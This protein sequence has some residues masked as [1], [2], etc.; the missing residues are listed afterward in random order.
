VA[1]LSLGKIRRIQ[2]LADDRGIFSICAMDHRGSLQR[3]LNPEHPDRVTYREMVDFK[4]DLCRA[5]APH[6]S[7]VLLDPPYGAGQAIVEGA[8][9]GGTALLVSIEATGYAG[10]GEARATELLPN[11]SVEK[12]KRL[13][14]SA[15]K[16]LLYYRPDVEKVASKQLDLVE[17]LAEE[18]EKVEFPLLVETRSYPIR[19]SERDPREFA[20]IQPDI[21]IETA[22]QIT[23]LPIDI[24]KTE[25]P[26]S[27]LYE[28]DEDRLLELCRE[29]DRASR[30]PW[31][32]LSAG[33]DYELF[34]KEVE[35]ACRA[36]ASGFLGGRALWQEATSAGPRKEHQRFLETVGAGRAKEL[37][38]LADSY[39]TPWYAKMGLDRE[40]LGTIEQGWYEAY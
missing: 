6:T 2:Q 40:R 3:M 14:A 34:R 39:G 38:A 8:L 35:I 4:L 25:F 24:F 30:V 16:L 37:T 27:P 26:T 12:A 17:R 5:L 21:V 10:T 7:A 29:L 11:W 32:I 9:P 19:D 1:R 36:G 15:T 13:G 18:H 31:V 28:P 33:V 22:R 20:R 23:A